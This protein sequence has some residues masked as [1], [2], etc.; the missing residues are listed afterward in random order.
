MNMAYLRG[1]PWSKANFQLSSIGWIRPRSCRDQKNNLIIPWS[2]MYIYNK[3]K[4]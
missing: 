1:F 3:L 4:N 2:I